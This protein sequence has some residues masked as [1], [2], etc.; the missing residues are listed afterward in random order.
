MY[1]LVT[2]TDYWSEMALQFQAGMMIFHRVNVSG[3][4][5]CCTDWRVALEISLKNL[6]PGKCQE[7]VSALYSEENKPGVNSSESLKT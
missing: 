6:L 5:D 1:L 4:T 2:K 7:I 3:H